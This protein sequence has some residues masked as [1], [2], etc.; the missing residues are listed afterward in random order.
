MP[1]G[2]RTDV[3]LRNRHALKEHLSDT[4]LNA[5]LQEN[6]QM[7]RAALGFADDLIV[8]EFRLGPSG[9]V[10]A[11]VLFINGL[12]EATTVDDFI[13]RSLTQ[14][15][16]IPAAQAVPEAGAAFEYLKE[17]ALSVAE[18]KEISTIGQVLTGILNG[19]SAVLMEGHERA[20]L[21]GTV[22]WKTRPLSESPVE[23]VVR[24]SREAFTEDLTTNISAVRRR[25]R[26]SRLR[27][28]KLTLGSLSETGVA[29]AYMEGLARE[30][31]L[32]EVRD[33][34]ARIQIDGILESGYIEEF[35]EDHKWS[36]FP[37]IEH[38]ER[39]DK[40]AAALL[41]G[42]VA[43]FTDGTP[44][45]LLVPVVLVQFLQASE[46]YYERYP[47][48]VVLRALR[49]MGVFVALFLPSLYVA[50]IT[51]HQEMIP[52]GLA[53]NIAGSRQGAPWP[54]FVEALIMEVIFELLREAGLRL[55]R[56]V[57][58]AVSIV[59]GL[60]IGDSAVRAGLA[61]PP[62]VIVVATTGIASF[63]IPAFGAAIPLRL[64]RFPIMIISAFAGLPGVTLAGILLA[65]H[66]ASLRSFGVPYMSPL[67]PGDVTGWK[68]VLFRAP[69]WA[70]KQRP[71][72]TAADTQ[73]MADRVVI[74]RRRGNQ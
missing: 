20:L 52:L 41:E 74:P 37:Q 36:P 60:V 12:A 33:R 43:I 30:E 62:M 67:A 14:A 21:A 48:A 68:D 54:A 61:T 63:A 56:P 2:S 39:P 26:H 18:I 7:A 51:Y 25:I 49:L 34:L 15:G 1:E 40:V 71:R 4:P 73:R 64:L 23:G 32:R 9:V 70:M 35:I 22:G 45:V 55:P 8:R 65:Y 44:V 58:Q 17:M 28:Q 24:G 5:V 10:T 50:I 16:Q 42:R 72:Q 31:I 47:M 11:A 53:L 59:G 13:L 69:W 6:L 27:V 29:I 38:T 3:R 57:G 19:N 66:L 46:D